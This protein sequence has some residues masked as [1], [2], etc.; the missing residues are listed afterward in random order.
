MYDR[1]QQAKHW[2]NFCHVYWNRPQIIRWWSATFFK[3]E[4]KKPFFFEKWVWKHK[5]VSEFD[6]DAKDTFRIHNRVFALQSIEILCPFL[7][8]SIGNS[9]REP[10]Y[11][12]IY[13]RTKFYQKCTI[14]GDP[15][16]TLMRGIA[17]IPVVEFL[18]GCFTIYN[19]YA[20]NGHAVSSRKPERIFLTP[21]RSMVLLSDTTIPNSIYLPKTSLWKSTEDSCLWQNRNSWR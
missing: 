19:W 13:K 15:L 9:Y 2:K 11:L 8:F 12:L 1:Q 10:S 20:D 4:T 3:K 14:Q 17:T 5:F 6:I 21:W 18:D 16:A 7:Y